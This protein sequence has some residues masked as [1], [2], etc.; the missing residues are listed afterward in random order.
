MNNHES[1]RTGEVR[2]VAKEILDNSEHIAKI[3]T[4]KVEG[5]LLPRVE[6]FKAQ[7]ED[8]ENKV[9]PFAREEMTIGQELGLNLFFNVINFCFKDPQTRQSYQYKAKDGTVYSRSTGL[10]FSL[11]ES[12]VDW[13]DINHV[14]T[15]DQKKWLEISQISKENPLYLGEERGE[16]LV[17]FANFLAEHGHKTVLEFLESVEFDAEQILEKLIGS[18]LFEDIFLKRAQVAVHNFDNVLV[19]RE[20]GQISNIEILTCM[21][22]YRI[23]QVF[24]NL[25]ALVLSGELN[26][27]LVEEIEIDS[28]SEQELA[29]RSSVIVIGLMLAEKLDTTASEIDGLLWAMSQQ[30]AKAGELTIPHMIVATDKY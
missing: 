18:K 5:A 1:K 15:L 27:Q 4:D 26:R 9:S 21:A 16:R 22:D 6:K 7:K 10:F 14:Q 23:P 25:G 11:A 2:R 20:R 3:D 29:L 30:M 12:G 8:N 17:H 13:N 28:S 19:R 24:Y